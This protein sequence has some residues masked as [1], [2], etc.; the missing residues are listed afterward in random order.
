MY[1]NIFVNQIDLKHF[2]LES[3][4]HNFARVCVCL[5]SIVSHLISLH[6]YIKLH[7]C[8]INCHEFGT[9]SSQFENISASN[10]LTKQT[11]QLNQ[12]T[13]PIRKLTCNKCD[14]KLQQN[15]INNNW[16]WL[17]GIYIY[18]LCMHVCM[19]ALQCL[20]AFAQ[21]PTSIVCVFLPFFFAPQ[22][23]LNTNRVAMCQIK[24]DTTIVYYTVLY[25]IA[26]NVQKML[27]YV[28]SIFDFW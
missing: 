14:M 13:E 25:R 28:C 18:M 3:C 19:L 2:K 7:E 17:I 26:T 21:M 1:C 27:I 11:N 9:I 24:C 20:C 15:L 22:H 6:N 8:C 12:P 4:I 5:C 23:H 10:R 16:L